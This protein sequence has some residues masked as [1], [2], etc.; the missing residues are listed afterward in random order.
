MW[1]RTLTMGSLSRTLRCALI[2]LCVFA[3]AFADNPANGPGPNGEDAEGGTPPE[4]AKPPAETKPSPAP[5]GPK[6][7]NVG[8]KRLGINMDRHVLRFKT[9]QTFKIAQFT[10]LHMDEPGGEEKD[11]NTRKVRSG[12]AWI[13]GGVV[14]HGAVYIWRKAR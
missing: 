10:D 11:A 2:A 12:R 6:G 4:A 7:A 3:M 14:L 5:V 9:D 8:L 13:G 1:D